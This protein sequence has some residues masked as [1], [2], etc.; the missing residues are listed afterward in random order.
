MEV[1]LGSF[2]RAPFPLFC[3]ASLH[4]KSSTQLGLRV[5]RRNEEK[6]VP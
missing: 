5:I 6:F 2:I 4:K 1:G 3:S